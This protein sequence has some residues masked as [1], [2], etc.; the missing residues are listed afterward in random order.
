MVDQHGLFG[1]VV[2]V[3]RQDKL[4]ALSG[5]KKIMLKYESSRHALVDLKD[6][7]ERIAAILQASGPIK[8]YPER[9]ILV[10]QNL[11]AIDLTSVPDEQLVA[12]VD[13]GGTPHAHTVILARALGVVA[14]VGVR[15][16]SYSG[17][18]DGVTAL[19]DGYER[20]FVL[21]PS[22]QQWVHYWSPS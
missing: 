4:T 16:L 20:R 11:S 5:L 9:T 10:G 7:A 12:V 1:E 3:M 2:Q 17:L 15:G 13:L 6:L 8:S 18:S 14:L 21:S 22:Y 19:V